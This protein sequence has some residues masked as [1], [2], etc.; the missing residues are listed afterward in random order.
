MQLDWQR[1]LRRVTE[2]RATCPAGIHEKAKLL[3]EILDI[4]ADSLEDATPAVCLAASL[5]S[6]LLRQATNQV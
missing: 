5:V 2:I 3:E 1:E 4:E 6:D